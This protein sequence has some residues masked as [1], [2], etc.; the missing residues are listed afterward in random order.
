M[1][2]KV[3]VTRVVCAILC[4]H[5]LEIIE[6][7]IYNWIGEDMGRGEWMTIRLCSNPRI[8]WLCEMSM[9]FFLPLLQIQGILNNCDPKNLSCMLTDYS[10]RILSSP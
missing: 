2:S 7:R 5:F 4:G 8:L 1:E 10:F 6:E 9:F 3:H